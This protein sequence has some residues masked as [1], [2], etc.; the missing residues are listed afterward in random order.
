MGRSDHDFKHPRLAQCAFCCEQEQEPVP[1]NTALLPF[2]GHIH[3]Q[4][5]GD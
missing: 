5:L 1:Q 4:L 2:A 3:A